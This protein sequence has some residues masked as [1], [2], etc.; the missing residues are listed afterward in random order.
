M[1]RRTRAALEAIQQEY[2]EWDISFI[3]GSRSFWRA[4]RVFNSPAAL[5]SIECFSAQ[6][7]RSRLYGNSLIVTPRD[8]LGLFPSDY[9][10]LD[11]GTMSPGDRDSRPGRTRETG[12]EEL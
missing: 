11:I 3:G 7:L 12:G 9:L 8:A 1:D 2:P 10:R 5:V 6:A 4:W